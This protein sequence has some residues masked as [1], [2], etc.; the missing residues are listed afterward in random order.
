MVPRNK[1]TLIFF[2][3]QAQNDAIEMNEKEEKLQHEELLTE[4]TIED[5][6]HVQTGLALVRL[7]GEKDELVNDI[8]WAFYPSLPSPATNSDKHVTGSARSEGYYKIEP[9]NKKAYLPDSF[10]SFATPTSRNVASKKKESLGSSRSNRAACR[11]LASAFRTGDSSATDNYKFIQLKARSK[12]LKFSKSRI[13]GWGLFAMEDIGAGEMVIEYVGEVIRTSVANEREKRYEAAGIGSS[14]FFKINED[15]VIDAT[16][17]G[18]SA[19]FINHSCS[20]N[21]YAKVIDV[22]SKKKIVLYS[23]RDIKAMEEITYDYKFP[24]EE[25]KIPCLCGAPNCRGTLN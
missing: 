20:P 11:Q 15:Y 7:K 23:K 8:P 19:R 4:R 10:L 1:I 22:D 6:E 3:L 14:Y 18:N 25:K 17:K 5:D 9:I 2:I 13:H 24:V 16:K 12:L 21:C